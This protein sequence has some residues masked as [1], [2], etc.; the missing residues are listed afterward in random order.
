MDL[1]HPIVKKFAVRMQ[2]SIQKSVYWYIVWPKNDEM[3][4]IAPANGI[5]LYEQFVKGI[6]MTLS[7]P[8]VI[9][10]P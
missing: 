3:P 1:C 10:N 5:Y 8:G 7:P 6:F 9:G 4:S 2:W